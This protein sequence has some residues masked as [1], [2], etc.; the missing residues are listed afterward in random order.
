[1]D[2]RHAVADD[3]QVE[4]FGHAGDL[5]PRGDAAGAHLVDHDDVYGAGLEHVAERHDGVEVLAAGDRGRERRGHSGEPGIIVMR[6]HVLEPIKADSGIFDSLADIDRLLDSP[7]LVDI[8]HQIHI[9]PDRLADEPGLLDF[10]RRRGDARQPE[11]HFGL[12]MALFA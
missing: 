7:A 11:L 10:A 12:A 1:M 2:L 9:G 3:G 6:G 8:A 4:G 5:E